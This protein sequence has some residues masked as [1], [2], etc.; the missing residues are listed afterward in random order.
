MFLLIISEKTGH[1]ERV[2]I[3]IIFKTSQCRPFFKLI[4]SMQFT[5]L[6][7]VRST[8]SIAFHGKLKNVSHPTQAS[9]DHAIYLRRLVAIINLEAT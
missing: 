3:S 2:V 5:T 8:F 7:K 1:K 6:Q 4:S 9:H